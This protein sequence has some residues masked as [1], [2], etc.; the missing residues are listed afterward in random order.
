MSNWN[1]LNKHRIGEGMY[2]SVQESD[3]SDQGRTMQP[4]ISVS[5]LTA[6]VA[7]EATLISPYHCPDDLVKVC[8]EFY[9]L[10]AQHCR[11]DGFP[12]DWPIVACR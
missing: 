2:A 11:L 5:K 3:G 10:T 4:F 12:E 8:R 7:G 6:I 9:K 1:F